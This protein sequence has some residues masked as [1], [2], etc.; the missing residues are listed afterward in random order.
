MSHTKVPF[1]KC[2]PG[3]Y[4][5]YGGRC[6]VIEADERR[7]AVVLGTDREATANADLFRA[8]PELLSSLKEAAKE[9]MECYEDTI[10]TPSGKHFKEMADCFLEVIRTAEG[11]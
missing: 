9:I 8:A 7:I 5:D 3:D 2:A 10:G 11:Y 6:I 1:T 4:G